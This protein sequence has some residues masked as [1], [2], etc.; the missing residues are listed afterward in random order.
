MAAAGVENL[1]CHALPFALNPPVGCCNGV[2]SGSLT[3]PLEQRPL[4]RQVVVKDPLKVAVPQPSP[5][6]ARPA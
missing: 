3:H 4:V 1:Y 2:A 6:L 5:Q